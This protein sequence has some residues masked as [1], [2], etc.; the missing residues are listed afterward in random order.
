MKEEQWEIPMVCRPELITK[1]HCKTMYSILKYHLKKIIINKKNKKNITVFLHD[2]QN[3]MMK[4]CSSK[5]R[6]N[7]AWCLSTW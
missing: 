5:H 6:P 3:K 4:I 7:I 1:Q 2:K